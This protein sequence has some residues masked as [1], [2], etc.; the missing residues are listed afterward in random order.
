MQDTTGRT[1]S[2]SPA[3]SI[4]DLFTRSGTQRTLST[5]KMAVDSEAGAAE[6]KLLGGHSLSRL[7]THSQKSSGLME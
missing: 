6:N 1:S 2:D 4:V 5:S 7:T 3:N